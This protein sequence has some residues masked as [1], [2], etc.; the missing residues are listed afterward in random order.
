MAI[1]LCWRMV[2]V[3]VID[4]MRTRFFCALSVTIC[5]FLA[6]NYFARIVTHH[7]RIVSAISRIVSPRLRTVR[8]KLADTKFCRSFVTMTPFY[9]VIMGEF[10]F[11]R[12]LFANGDCHLR[13]DIRQSCTD[14]QVELPH[15]LNR[16]LYLLTV[17]ALIWQCAQ[18]HEKTSISD[19]NER[20]VM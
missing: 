6:I 4:Y 7:A 17:C 9:C 16:D 14:I 11:L 10:L 19:L 20:I 5:T 8:P 1:S 2:P 13:T 3:Y 18:K 12:K 15:F